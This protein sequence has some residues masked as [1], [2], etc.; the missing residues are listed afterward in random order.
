M[1][2]RTPPCPVPPGKKYCFQCAS[3]LAQDS[4]YPGRSAPDGLSS[5]CKAC[6]EAKRVERLRIDR[7]MEETWQRL[8]APAGS[9]H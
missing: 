3:L 7:L 1:P 6:K 4:F 8:N 9:S 2:R 5:P